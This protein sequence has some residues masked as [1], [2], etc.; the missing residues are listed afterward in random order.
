MAGPAGRN[1]DYD[2]YCFMSF[3]KTRNVIASVQAGKK[4]DTETQS[5][6]KAELMTGAGMGDLPPSHINGQLIISQA[7]PPEA[8]TFAEASMPTHAIDVPPSSIQTVPTGGSVGSK[9]L[10]V[11]DEA[12]TGEPKKRYFSAAPKKSKK[13]KSDLEVIPKKHCKLRYFL[14]IP[15]SE[16]ESDS[17]DSAK[18]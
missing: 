6:A 9:H 16:N 1:G 17:D 11:D 18:H 10:F 15:S 12:A 8:D 13:K 4:T 5:P 7:A 2:P 3:Y 14:G